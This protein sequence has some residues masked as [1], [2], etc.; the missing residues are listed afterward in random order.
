MNYRKFFFLPILALTLGGC[1]GAPSKQEISKADYG[2]QPVSAKAK[3]AATNLISSTLIDPYSAVI[4]CGEPTKG[5]LNMN[6]K[7]SY[8]YLVEC[9]VNAK[10]RYGGYT[11]EQER[12]FWIRNGA[13]DEIEPPFKFGSA[14]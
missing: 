7:N 14:N 3:L 12:Y 4:K 2:S 1:A 11:G 6:F 9:K 10:N 8:G 5:W 13:M